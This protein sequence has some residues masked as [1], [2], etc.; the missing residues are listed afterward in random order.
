MSLLSSNGWSIPFRSKSL[1]GGFSFL[2]GGGGFICWGGGGGEGATSKQEGGKSHERGK[3]CIL[4]S[5]ARNATS[6]F[7]RNL[8]YRVPA[9]IS[10]FLA[11]GLII[12][13]SCV[14]RNQINFKLIL[15]GIYCNCLMRLLEIVPVLKVSIIISIGNSNRSLFA[16][17]IPF[18]NIK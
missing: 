9:V 6:L 2:G 15:L 10:C 13:S 8:H 3:G 14:V 4:T 16:S 1:V 12:K 5:K 18:E 17:G 11:T 7:L